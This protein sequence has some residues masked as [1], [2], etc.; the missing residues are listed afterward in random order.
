MVEGNILETGGSGGNSSLREKDTS[1]ETSLQKSG[2]GGPKK[3]IT[4]L[5]QWVCMEHNNK[6][7]L[8][9]K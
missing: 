8:G 3:A 9:V 4:E 2:A 1:L 7:L 5:V 6:L